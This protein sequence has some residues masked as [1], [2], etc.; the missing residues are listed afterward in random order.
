MAGYTVPRSLTQLLLVKKL[1]PSGDLFRFQKMRASVSGGRGF[2]KRRQGVPSSP[3]S[4]E[5]PA[6]KSH[7]PRSLIDDEQVLKLLSSHP[8]ERCWGPRGGCLCCVSLWAQVQGS[9]EHPAAPMVPFH[10]RASSVVSCLNSCK[11]KDHWPN[12]NRVIILH[13]QNF[14]ER[15]FIFPAGSLL[16]PTF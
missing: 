2:G 8:P 10:S 7:L 6:P 5:A 3:G 9:K 4:L 14:L 1:N 12:S 11:L 15:R 16:S 13:F